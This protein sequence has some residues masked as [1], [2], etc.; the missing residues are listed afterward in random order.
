[1]TSVPAIPTDITVV[2]RLAG[3]DASAADELFVRYAGAVFSLACRLSR[4][5]AIAEDATQDA[6]VQAWR[7]ASRYD[8]TRGTVRSWLFMIARAR[9]LD[10]LR[11]RQNRDAWQTPLDASPEVA[12]RDAGVCLDGMLSASEDASR[13]NAALAILP[14]ADRRLIDLAYFEGLSHT[15]IADRLTVPL[16]TVK[17]H[18]R[19]VMRL[20][21]HAIAEQPARPFEWSPD[22]TSAPAPDAPLRDVNV[23]V[24]D[25]DADTLRLLTLVLERAGACVVPA[26]SAAQARR[27]LA[28]VWPDVFVTDIEMPTEDGYSLLQGVREIGGERMVPAVAFTAHD[29]TEDHQRARRAGFCL[30]LPKPIRPA[31]LVRRLADILREPDVQ[32]LAATPS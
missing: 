10:R 5:A 16:G 29:S 32:V 14:E 26:S 24:V 19:R 2:E 13:V 28:T 23:V 6:F 1:M 25:D 3:G 8:A 11:S 27:R 12:I 15:E 21:R 17:T 4:D 22:R 7:E 30:H 20:M 18:M 31:L 9:T